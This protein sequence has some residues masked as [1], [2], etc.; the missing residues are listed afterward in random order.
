MLA[1]VHHDVINAFGRLIAY[2][3]GA[4]LPLLA[5]A[6]GGRAFSRGLLTLRS[7]SATLQR[8]GGVMI[9][10][11]AI[12]SLLGWDVEVQLRLASLFPSLPF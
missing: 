2:G 4:A 12:A 7:H 1:A 5:I 3:M 10:V 9:V 11:T 8:V 6:Y